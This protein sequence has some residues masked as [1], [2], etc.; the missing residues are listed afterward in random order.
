MSQ[1]INSVLIVD[2][3]RLPRMMGRSILSKDFPEITIHE[4]SNGDEAL[5]LSREQ[6][7]DLALLD[8]NMPGL[9]GI[10]LGRII[11]TESL[12]RHICFVSANIQS[13]S[14]EQANALGAQFIAKPISE[15]K[16]VD[17]INGLQ[18]S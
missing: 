8:I 3:N 16:L 4:A 11:Q 9:G 10:E 15:E 18:N 12:A 5:A 1:V 7:I 17:L 13:A 14:I 6:E 2:D